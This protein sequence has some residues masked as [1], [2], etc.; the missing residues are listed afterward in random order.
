MLTDIGKSV[1]ACL[2]AFE[3]KKFDESGSS[4]FGVELAR[5]DP[6]PHGRVNP[7]YLF[8]NETNYHSKP[9]RFE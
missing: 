2:M 8:K 1:F 6:R 3:R 4:I 9:N 7:L 5:A